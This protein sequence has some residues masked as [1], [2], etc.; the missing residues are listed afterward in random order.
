MTWIDDIT[1]YF[2]ISTINLKGVYWSFHWFNDS[3]TREF[4]LVTRGLPLPLGEKLFI[5]KTFHEVRQEITRK[6]FII[7]HLFCV[8]LVLKLLNIFFVL[9][10]SNCKG[11]VIFQI[12]GHRPE[13]LLKKRLWD[14]CFPVNFDKFL[15][16]PFL[17]EHLRWLLLIAV[18]VI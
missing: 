6:A 5:I 3:W 17:K 15:R 4:E 18:Q 7:I 8:V 11:H 14:R 12:A 10:N 13:T 1:Y 9:L 2:L 16:T